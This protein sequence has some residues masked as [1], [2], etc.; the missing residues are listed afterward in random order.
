MDTKSWKG[1]KVGVGEYG[2][3]TYP[4]AFS[5]K[6][7]DF[8]IPVLGYVLHKYRYAHRLAATVYNSYG[9]GPV[10]GVPPDGSGGIKKI[11]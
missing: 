4:H 7:Y 3:R 8:D 6:V 11:F 10:S 5:S 9:S 2:R 1:E